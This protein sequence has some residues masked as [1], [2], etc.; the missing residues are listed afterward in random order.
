MES[1]HI[2][3]VVTEDFIYALHSKSYWKNR[4]T[5][6]H[7]HIEWFESIDTEIAWQIYSVKGVSKMRSVPA[8]LAILYI[9][10][11]RSSY[12]LVIFSGYFPST[13]E[14]IWLPHDQFQW[15]NSGK[16][17]KIHCKKLHITCGVTKTN[18]YDESCAYFMEYIVY[19]VYW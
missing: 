19:F 11:S 17:G 7:Q 5:Y 2:L 3:G 1:L 13:G 18:K 4:N 8:F 9:Q 12:T 15:R 6:L 14:I 16:F 10:V